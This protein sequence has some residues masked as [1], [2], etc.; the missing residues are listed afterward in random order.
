MKN[1]VF[2]LSGA[3]IFSSGANQSFA[4]SG[5]LPDGWRGLVDGLAIYQGDADLSGRGAF[6]ASR[7]F[8]RAGAIYRFDNEASAGILVSSGRF[9][10]D[11]DNPLNQPWDDINDFRVSAPIRFSVGESANVFF[12]PSVRYDYQRGVSMSD[13]ATYGAFAG[14]TWRINERL[15]IGPAIG[16]Y[17]QLDED[18]LDV[19]PALLVDWNFADRWNLSTG[20][21]LGA[22]QGPGLSLTFNQSKTLSFSL[23][24]RYESV[25]FRLDN[26]G[27][28]PGGV[29]EDSSFPVVA[30]VQYKPNP[31]MSFT[32][33]VGA[34]FDGEL[35]LTNAAGTS[36]SRQSYDTA[37]IAGLAFRIFF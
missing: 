13:G 37:P 27:L 19:F 2:L 20:T 31:A 4:Q 5:P 18:G 22:T 9:S 6:S 3:A 16:A 25:R 15:T 26:A 35:E 36:V 24:A 34:E 21:G 7:A 12:I 1:I 14:I 10:Y 11:F 17:S 23:G 29:G 32:A 28:A 30:S 33:F 8:V